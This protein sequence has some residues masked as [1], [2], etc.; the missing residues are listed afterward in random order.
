[1]PYVS[2]IF[3]TLLAALGGWAYQTSGMVSKTALIP[4][5]PGV[6]L[7]VCG[8]VALNEKLLKHAMHGAATFGL[9]GFLAGL[10]NW[11]VLLT[12]GEPVGSTKSIASGGM[13]LLC[14]IFVALCVKSFIDVPRAR[15]RAASAPTTV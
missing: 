14:G 13:G 12:K 15:A 8:V 5:L 7:L 9:L 1:M 2:I 6:L 10:G 11:I 4:A 3:G